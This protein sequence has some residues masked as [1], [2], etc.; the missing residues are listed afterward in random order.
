[1]MGMTLGHLVRSLFHCIFGG[2]VGRVSGLG[3]GIFVPTGVE[4]KSDFF[5]FVVVVPIG[6]ESKGGRLIKKI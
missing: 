5:S 2:S 6:A 4:S 1:M 3:F